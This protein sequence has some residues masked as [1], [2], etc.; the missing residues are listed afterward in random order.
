MSAADVP[1]LPKGPEPPARP[2]E[3]DVLLVLRPLGDS[4]VPADLRLRQ[5]LKCLLRR[6]RLRCMK[7]VDVPREE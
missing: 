4:D 3:P 7:C 1:L 6:F 5:A 2:P